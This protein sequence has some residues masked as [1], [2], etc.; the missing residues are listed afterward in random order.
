VTT[1]YKDPREDLVDHLLGQSS[2]RAKPR[3]IIQKYRSKGFLLPEDW[4]FLERVAAGYPGRRV[5][6]LDPAFDRQLSVW[7]LDLG[8][9]VEDV[10]DLSGRKRKS[11]ELERERGEGRVIVIRGP[12]RAPSLQE[13]RQ[14]KR[15]GEG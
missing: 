5:R 3:A 9:T 2:L 1:I 13:L 6:A 4:D 14:K 8:L 10:M 7:L 11:R 15:L 12:V